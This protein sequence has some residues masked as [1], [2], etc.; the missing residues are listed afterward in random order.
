MQLNC[1]LLKTTISSF[2]LLTFITHGMFLPLWNIWHLIA[3]HFHLI[4]YLEAHSFTSVH[5]IRAF[6]TPSHR[7]HKRY[8]QSILSSTLFVDLYLDILYI[9]IFRFFVMLCFLSLWQP[10]VQSSFPISW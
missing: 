6:V 1:N 10:Q 3:Q 7:C 9:F 8:T 5:L 2:S 4:C